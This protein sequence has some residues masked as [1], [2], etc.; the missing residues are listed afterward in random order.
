MASLGYVRSTVEEEFVFEGLATATP[1]DEQ[2]F[3]LGEAA[4]VDL[5][6]RITPARV[7]AHRAATKAVL[8]TGD[9]L[10]TAV[11]LDHAHHQTQELAG[12]RRQLIERAA[13]DLVGELVGKCDV[14]EGHLDVSQLPV[15]AA[16]GS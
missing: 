6:L 16:R 10:R 14:C 7:L 4:Q 8:R 11:L 3:Q 15:A 12:L 1:M 5:Q 2:V 13:Q 9:V